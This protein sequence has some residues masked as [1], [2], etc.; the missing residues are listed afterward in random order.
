MVITE[1][2]D[3]YME[4][5]L[6]KMIYKCLHPKPRL[7]C[8]CNHFQGK[9]TQEMEWYKC[10]CGGWMSEKRIFESHTKKGQQQTL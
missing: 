4:E 5:Y 2:L 8:V 6:R 1:H 7:I 9:G 3:K 10:K